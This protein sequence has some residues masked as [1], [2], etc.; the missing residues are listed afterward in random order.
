M[1]ETRSASDNPEAM[2]CS[3]SA[4]VFT[5]IPTC[6]VDDSDFQPHLSGELVKDRQLPWHGDRTRYRLWFRDH[7]INHLGRSA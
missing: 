3:G 5:T 7:R 2:V 1:S 4:V 6:R